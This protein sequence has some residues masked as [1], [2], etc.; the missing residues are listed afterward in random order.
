MERTSARSK[1]VF[2][3]RGVPNAIESLSGVS[4]L[5]SRRLGDISSDDIQVFS[6][7][8]SLHFRETP[9][10]K[11]ATIMFKIDPSI[12]SASHDRNEW[13]ISRGMETNCNVDLILDTHFIGMTPLNDVSPKDHAYDCIAISGLDSHPFGSWQP[14][15]GDKTFMWIRDSLPK[16]IDNT[17]AILYGYESGLHDSQSFQ[18]IPDLAL[19][20]IDQLQTYGWGLAFAKPIAFLAH[21]LGG[22]LLKQAL[23]KLSSMENESYNSLI[24]LVRGAVFFGVPNLGMEQ[25]HFQAIVQD[26][27][28]E[29]LVDDI[30]RNS[31]YLRQLNKEFHNNS[32]NTKIACF[33]AYETSESPTVVFARG[34]H[35]YDSVIHRLSTILS[36]AENNLSFVEDMPRQKHEPETF[37]NKHETTPS[38]NYAGRESLSKA[39][40]PSEPRRLDLSTELLSFKRI[41]G[42]S[43]VEE[44][45]FEAATP[46]TVHAFLGCLQAEQAKSMSMMYMKRLDPFIE[47]MK[48][49]EY[50]TEAAHVFSE[51]S[52]KMKF[53]WGSLEYIIRTAS[54]LPEAL[55]SVLDAYLE[56]GEQIPLASALQEITASSFHLKEGLVLVFKDV[57]QFH[58]EAIRRFKQPNWK[59]LFAASWRDFTLE[60]KHIQQNIERSKRLIENKASLVEFEEIQNHRISAINSFQ[61]DKITQNERHRAMVLQWL[62]PL[63]IETEQERLRGIRSICKDPGRWLLEDS[64]FQNWFNPE[65]STRP[66]LW[67]SGIPG[68]GK[69][70]LTSVVVDATRK[71]LD[72][73][74]AMFYFKY[75]QDMRSSFLGFARSILAQILGQNPHLLPYFH[76]KASMSG[77]ASLLSSSIAKEMMQTALSNC[78]KLYLIVDG[79]DECGR[80]ERR[81]IT[82]W[83]QDTVQD[84]LVTNADSIRCLFVSQ[85]DGA[86]REDLEGV[87]NIKITN[88]NQDDVAEFAAAW[89]K[90]IERKFGKVRQNNCRISQI[91]PA[92][93]QGM[94]IYAELFA[95]YIE[96]QLNLAKVLEALEPTNLPVNL[97]HVYERILDRI[98]ESQG[99][100]TVGHVREVLGWMVC[101][102][103]PLRWREIQAAICIDLDN[104]RIDYLRETSDSPKGLFASLVEVQVDGTVQLVHETARNFLLRNKFINADEVEYSLSV[105]SLSYLTLP[106]IDTQWCD[107]KSDLISGTYAF[108]DYASACWAKHFLAAISQLQAGGRLNLLQETLETFIESHW[109]PEHKALADTKRV[110]KTLTLIHS[111]DMVEKIVQAISW[112]NKQSGKHGQGPSS[113]EALD[114]WQLTG[115]IRLVFE[116][117]VTSSLPN[118]ELKQLQR[119]YGE[120]HYKCPRINCHRYYDGFMTADERNHHINKHDRPFLCIVSG[121][122]YEIFGYPTKDELKK[123]LFNHHGTDL[124]DDTYDDEFPDPPK[125]EKE[126]TTGDN[127]T[128][129]CHLCDK[130]FTRNHNLKGHLRTHQGVKPFAC[131]TCAETFTRKTDRDRHQRGHGDKKLMCSGSL[132]DGGSWGCQETFSRTDRLASHFRS[133]KGQKCI[134]PLLQ[135]KQKDG[136]TPAEGE[137]NIFVGQTGDNAGSLLEAGRI[138]PSFK[139]FIHLCGLIHPDIDVSAPEDL[140]PLVNDNVT[141]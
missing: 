64:R 25:A 115:R 132:K 61:K 51:V 17:R 19:G 32:L 88:E 6:L 138:L 114:L 105:L 113:D 65:F 1:I 54:T 74:V 67:L 46:D 127:A 81:E 57:L 27:P 73:T 120:N 38:E 106:A 134:Q 69:T 24:G 48:Q 90:R 16:H 59:Q 83:L 123:H 37:N 50:V 94:F 85:D 130:K 139:D 71:V 5:V 31:N 86:A 35:H 55:H 68:A 93:A 108:Y 66:L 109:S 26:N 15:G 118:D 102:R 140:I 82:A 62:S 47:S 75:G 8:T 49:L 18:T 4:E 119:F 80:A 122:P 10:S 11:V 78:M 99:D 33:W 126:K 77:D 20:L 117:L 40:T 92:R 22:I 110:Q 131:S 133:K 30:G 23:V 41:S 141:K 89:D 101:A 2:R 135:E 36:V 107:I 13:S 34:S 79:L 29:A 72:T 125:K 56:I 21:S 43:D 116:E 95:K 12:L 70:I 129:Q 3:L 44:A 39:T 124:F 28:N 42:L 52:Q 137:D 53:I 112:A 63:N 136:N 60:V 7:A 100:H 58:R 84:L 104:E 14:R 96:D 45:A 128:F 91:I 121:C 87:P 76:E 111:S 98:L 97:D 9:R 103:R